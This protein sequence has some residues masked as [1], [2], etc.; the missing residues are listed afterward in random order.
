MSMK[1]Q[2]TEQGPP[3]FIVARINRFRKHGGEGPGQTQTT[4][5]DDSQS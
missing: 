1:K 5:Q 2:K 3:V 4:K